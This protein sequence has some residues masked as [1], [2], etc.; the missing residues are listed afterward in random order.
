MLVSNVKLILDG[1]VKNNNLKAREEPLDN[2]PEV[3]VYGK[4]LPAKGIFFR[5]INGL[6]LENVSVET[7][8]EDAREPF[9]FDKT[10]NVSI[11]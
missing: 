5:H 11:L 2:Y 4:L 9:V 10:I 8:R 1:G 3:D 7:Y 6:V